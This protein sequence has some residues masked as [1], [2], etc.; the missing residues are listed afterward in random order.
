MPFSIGA[1]IDQGLFDKW[2][3]PMAA[4]SLERPNTMAPDALVISD[5]TVNEM[6]RTELRLIYVEEC[7]HALL[8]LS[9][10]RY[11]DQAL[12]S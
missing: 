6:P 11:G 10:S 1:D 3:E 9:R 12:T 2:M 5:L 4:L 7:N 8:E